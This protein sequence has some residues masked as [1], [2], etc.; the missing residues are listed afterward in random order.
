MA[1]IKNRKKVVGIQNENACCKPQLFLRFI[2][3]FQ[4]A[5]SF[6]V[7]CLPRL[8]SITVSVISPRCLLL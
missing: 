5:F 6:N 7:A 8:L 2:L 3:L 4:S 1:E